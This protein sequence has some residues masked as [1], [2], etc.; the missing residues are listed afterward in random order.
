MAH[1]ALR[2][3]SAFLN[4]SWA[5]TGITGGLVGH[6]EHV[7]G[8]VHVGRQRNR[9]LQLRDAI[10]RAP[11]FDERRAQPSPCHGRRWIPLH[12]LLEL[13]HR[14]LIVLQIPEAHTEAVCAVERRPDASALS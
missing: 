7:M 1:R 9:T 6:P 14:Q 2:N 3:C 8:F 12:G 10:S 13:L 4:D 11:E 5:R